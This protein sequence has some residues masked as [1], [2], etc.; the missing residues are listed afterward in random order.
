MIAILIGGIENCAKTSAWHGIREVAFASQSKFALSHW[1]PVGAFIASITIAKNVSESFGRTN[2]Y[3]R[4]IIYIYKTEFVSVCTQWIQKPYIQS[5]RN[6][7]KS[8]GVF[9]EM[10][11]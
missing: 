3:Q 2:R 9:P 7:G 10:F 8:L 6:F 11:L 1:D 5:A 4:N